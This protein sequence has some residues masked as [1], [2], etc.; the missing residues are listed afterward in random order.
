MTGMVDNG[1]SS[2][3]LSEF[4][5]DTTVERVGDR[6]HAVVSD[7]WDVG[8]NPNGGHVLALLLRAISGAAPSP[9]PLTVTAHYLRT[10]DHR[11]ASIS[12]DV[13]RSGRRFATATA[14]LEQGGRE[15]V[16]AL[17]TFGDLAAA[18]GPTRIDAPPPDLL[19]P[20]ECYDVLIGRSPKGLAAAPVLLQ[21]FDVRL[22]PT[23]GMAAG[24]TA[25][26]G[27]PAGTSSP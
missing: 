2:A 3:P 15:R 14:A 16:R 26:S 24:R 20:D 19:P 17:A 13:I 11:D 8:V 9:D 27:T 25:S 4:D 12:V 6:W 5:A 22:P 21:R 10:S 18:V 23:S 1:S 7:R